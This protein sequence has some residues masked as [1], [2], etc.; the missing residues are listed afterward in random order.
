MQTWRGFKYK[1]DSDQA[2]S[3][4][5]VLASCVVRL[6]ESWRAWTSFQMLL[7]F[8]YNVITQPVPHKIKQ[9]IAMEGG[10]SGVDWD[11]IRDDF[12]V[13]EES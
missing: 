12:S 7:P 9:A 3:Y 4:L 5:L 13:R 8:A 11:W 2:P 10:A 1:I 6:W